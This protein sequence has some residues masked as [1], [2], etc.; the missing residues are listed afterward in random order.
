[1]TAPTTWTATDGSGAG[2]T[3]ATN[4][5]TRYVKNGKVCVVSFMIQW[6]TTSDTHT[7]QINGIP[8]A[9]TAYSGT[10]NWVTGGTVS[11]EVGSVSSV[12]GRAAMQPGGTSLFLFGNGNQM[13]NANMSGGIVRGT[14]TYMTN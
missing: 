11:M 4:A 9:C 8:A 1:V 6:P 2:L 5:D 10:F 14:I 12:L 3:F 7:A 13:T